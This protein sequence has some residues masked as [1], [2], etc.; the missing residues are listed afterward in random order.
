[1]TRR[2]TGIVA[3][4]RWSGEYFGFF[5]NGYLFSGA[6][7]YVGW[8]SDE[9]AVWR[10]DGRFLGEIVDENYILRRDAMVE[11]IP[12]IPLIPPIPPIPVIPF[13]PRIPRIPRLG[14]SDAL[15]AFHAE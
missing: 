12:R 3:I 15:D 13:L 7:E 1:V 10:G 2:T 14:W 6:G 5:L 4:H 11:P 8:V 9:G